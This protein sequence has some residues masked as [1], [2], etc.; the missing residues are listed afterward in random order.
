MAGTKAKLEDG[1]PNCWRCA[2]MAISWD[3]SMP[4]LC[5]QIGFKTRELPAR[6]VLK[7]DGRHCLGFEQKRASPQPSSPQPSAPQP[8]PRRAA[9]P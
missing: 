3:A 5:R 4:Y 2:H 1:C 6:A 8:Q 9:R 7:L